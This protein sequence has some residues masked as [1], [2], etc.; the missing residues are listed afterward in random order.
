MH[1][2]QIKEAWLGSLGNKWVGSCWNWD[3]KLRRQL[4]D[5]ELDQWNYFMLAL[6]NFSIRKGIVD[7][8]A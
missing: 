3:V 6:N 7:D 5:W 2:L 4:F 1:W 8:L